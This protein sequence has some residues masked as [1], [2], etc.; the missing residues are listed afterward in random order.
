[1]MVPKIWTSVNL[2]FA[3]RS[4]AFFLSHVSHLI[5]MQN[6]DITYQ[7]VDKYTRH[8]KVNDRYS[9]IQ[10]EPVIYEL[11]LHA[12]GTLAGCIRLSGRLLSKHLQTGQRFCLRTRSQRSF[13]GDNT[14]G[15]GEGHANQQGQRPQDEDEEDSRRGI[16][17]E[18]QTVTS[19]RS[20]NLRQDKIH[21]LTIR[22][23]WQCRWFAKWDG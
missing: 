17:E 21:K 2:G 15:P 7:K 13:H 22:K 10:H 5:K 18:H 19:D 6:E 1:M 8:S 20:I 23:K 14:P 9:R 4:R 16:D 12:G 3:A 11:R